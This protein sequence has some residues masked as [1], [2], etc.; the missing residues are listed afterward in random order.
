MNLDARMINTDPQE[1]YKSDVCVISLAVFV[2]SATRLESIS[3]LRLNPSGQVDEN[4]WVRNT[5]VW[6]D[7]APREIPQGNKRRE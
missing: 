5:A 4:R 3:S 6:I 1:E 7:G 2:V